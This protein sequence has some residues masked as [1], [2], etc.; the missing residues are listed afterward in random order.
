MT[1][2]PPPMPAIVAFATMET[3]RSAYSG[4]GLKVEL[5]GGALA[6]VTAGR[7]RASLL[8]GW[9]AKVGDTLLVGLAG[10]ERAGGR[11]GARLHGEAWAPW[12]SLVATCGTAERTCWSRA[13]A[14][15]DVGHGLRV[16]PEVVLSTDRAALGIAATGLRLGR[17]ELEVSG[18]LSR[19]WRGRAGGY[20]GLAV[21]VR[22]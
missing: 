4:A 9:Q 1:D 15:L 18:G 20:V 13:R 10:A 8:G 2:L 21:V 12:G 22:P 19:D 5:P 6:M 14:G 17:Y 7:D 11:T 3:G 16:G